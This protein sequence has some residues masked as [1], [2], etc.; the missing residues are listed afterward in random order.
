MKYKATTKENKLGEEF[1]CAIKRQV[2]I[3]KFIKRKGFILHTFI[4]VCLHKQDTH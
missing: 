3:L 2:F 1:P 4:F